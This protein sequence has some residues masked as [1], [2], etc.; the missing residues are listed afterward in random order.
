MRKLFLFFFLFSL[1]SCS[2]SQ[3]KTAEY[4]V[5][6]QN[7]VYAYSV[8]DEQIKDVYVD[9]AIQDYIDV[10]ELYTIYQNYLPPAY[11]SMGTSNVALEKAE[12]IDN[13]VVYEV[14]SFIYLVQDLDVFASLLSKTNQLLGYQGSK[15]ICKD[16]IIA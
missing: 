5:A 9:Y 16:K 14:D 12:V 10:F 15:I 3:P 4:E 6:E 8:E 11:T 2:E 7:L 13:V 1:S